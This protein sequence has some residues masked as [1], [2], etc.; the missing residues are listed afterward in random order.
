MIPILFD[1]KAKSFTSN[2]LGRL[3]DAISC[4][5]TEERN[6]PFEL[7]MEY[8][9]FGNLFDQISEDKIIVASASNDSYDD[10]THNQAF[11]IYKIS[12]PINGIVTIYA[13]H[14]SYLLSKMIVMPF[15]ASSVSDAFTKIPQYAAGYTV[16]TFPFS[17]WTNKTVSGTFKVEEPKAIR[18]LLGGEGGSIL[19]TYGKGEY[20]FDNFTVKL[21]T[22]RGGNNHVTIRYGK[23]LTDLKR[24]TDI[25]N[26]YVGIVPYWKGQVQSG[27]DYVDEIVTLSEK[28]IFNTSHQNDFA[29]AIIKPVDFSSDFDEKPTEAQLRTKAQTYLTNN[30]GWEIKENLDVSFINLADTV[31]YQDLAVLQAV[32]L[33]DTITVEYPRLGVSTTAKVV[34]TVWNSLTDRY[35]SVEIGEAKTNLGGYISDEISESTPENMATKGDVDAAVADAW[36]NFEQE[37]DD[38]LEHQRQ[39][40]N[41]GLGGYVVIKTNA[42]TGYPEEIVVMNTPKTSTATKVI[43]INQNGIGMSTGTGA[44]NMANSKTLWTIDGTF[45]ADNINAGTLNAARIAAKSIAVGKLTG[46]LSDATHSSSIDMDTGTITIGTVVVGSKNSLQSNNTGV[47]LSSDGFAVGQYRGSN[48]SG[49]YSYHSALVIPAAR[50]TKTVYDSKF[51]DNDGSVIIGK[52]YMRRYPPWDEAYNAS[53]NPQGYKSGGSPYTNFGMYGDDQGRYYTP[54]S[55]HT[56]NQAKNQYEDAENYFEGYTTMGHTKVFHDLYI[57]DSDAPNHG[58]LG[59]WGSIEASGSISPNTNPSDEKLKT[60]IK[61]ISEEEAIRFIM[62][63]DPVEFRWKDID[64]NKFQDKKAL[65][66]GLIA[67]RVQETNPKWDPIGESS[68]GLGLRYIDM[69]ADLIKVV[70]HQEK[71]IEKLKSVIKME[72][73]KR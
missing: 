53:S 14:I 46:I 30:N 44:Y 65:R 61:S 70:Q 7:E 49:G 60:D 10:G 40:I 64:E 12:R 17:F 34:K 6:G 51:P 19:D 24:D 35:E 1:G 38:S 20:K 63:Q 55:I 31:E 69:I 5:V 66:H 22:N 62:A 3:S 41:G 16:S 26:A 25:T 56:G 15:T 54:G 58:F 45:S 43:R 57:S 68:K 37:M 47:Y 18:P 72:E 42:S 21:Y 52:M 39:L 29:Y 2:G 59:V 50:N 9:I 36:A 67:Q 33:C 11:H 71:E 73:D 4:R 48:Q 13:E 8:P 27:D 32:N 28:V 23:N